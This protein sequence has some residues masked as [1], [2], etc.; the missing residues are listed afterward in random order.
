MLSPTDSILVVDDNPDDLRLLVTLLSRRGHVVRPALS[1][2]LALAAAQSQPPSLILLDIQMPLMD[3]YATCRQLKADACTAAI[4]VIFISAR[5]EVFDKVQAFAEGGV[6][7]ISKPFQAEE[8]VARIETQLR[9]AAMQRH[10][11]AQNRLLQQEIAERT[12]VEAELQRHQN[13]L[14]ELVDERTTEIR[15]AYARLEQEI[16]ERA[17]AEEALLLTRFTVERVA[18]ALYWMTPD[19]RFVDV[20][21]AACQMLGYTRAELLN[22][23]VFNIDPQLSWSDW[24]QTWQVLRENGTATLETMH[25]TRDGRLIPVELVANFIA[26]GDRELDCAFVRD[27]SERRRVEEARRAQ[28]QAEAA[29]QA[30]SAFLAHMSHELR[31]PLTGILGAAS[32]LKMQSL[33]QAALD[34]LNIIEY[35][36]DHLLTLINDILDLAKIEAGK[37][38]LTPTDVQLP[39]LLDKIIGMIHSRAAAKALSLTCNIPAALPAIVQVDEKCLRQVLLNLLSNAVKFTERGAVT[40]LVEMLDS[41]CVMQGHVRLRFTVTDTGVGITPDQLERIF[42]PFEQAGVVRKRSEGTGLG[43]AIS[44]QLVA[45]MGGQ[46]QVQS[47]IDQGSSFWF[48]LSLPCQ[49][50]DAGAGNDLVLPP[51]ADLEA[52]YLNAQRGNL[53]LIYVHARSLAE[54]EPRYQPFAAQIGELALAYEDQ[55]VCARLS[56]YLEL[57]S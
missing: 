36:G 42:L 28:E 56:A 57:S 3:G 4:P 12:R 18:D 20:N 46:L 8:V 23:T 15:M 25:Q 31:T 24:E 2:A 54:N 48:D 39:V 38:E 51:R 52:M 27:I 55:D 34:C 10:L 29:N 33:D 5:N 43:L 21:A 14:E 49:Q 45:L 9:L 19:G 35:S 17:R 26:F 47:Q 41:A 30:K 53:L 50:G 32:L 22:M 40:L 1:G 7:Y 44:R 16:A 11:E 13:Q 37:T 6:D